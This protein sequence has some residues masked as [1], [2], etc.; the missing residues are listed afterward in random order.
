MRTLFLILL[1]LHGLS[2]AM[3]AMGLVNALFT[4]AGLVAGSRNTAKE[5]GLAI[6]AMVL[7]AGIGLWAWRL[8]EQARTT[9]AT[10]VLVVFWAAIFALVFFAATHARWN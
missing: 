9:S 3:L 5:W 1:G 10:V 7:F 8:S 4:A 2:T 6:G